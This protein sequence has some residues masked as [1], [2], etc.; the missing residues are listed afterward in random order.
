MLLPLPLV[1]QHRE[2]EQNTM[3]LREALLFCV[4]GVLSAVYALDNGLAQTPPS[5]YM[6][7]ISVNSIHSLTVTLFVLCHSGMAGMGTIWL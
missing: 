6:Y 4:L 7:N 1:D 2:L 5:E 3:K